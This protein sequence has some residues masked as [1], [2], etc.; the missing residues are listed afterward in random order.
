MS[1]IDV[2][3]TIEGKTGSGKTKILSILMNALRE[4]KIQ[5][6]ILHEN[7]NIPIHDTEI[8]HIKEI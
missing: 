6:A 7:E 3:I 4:Q 8:M 5:V 2:K 1:K